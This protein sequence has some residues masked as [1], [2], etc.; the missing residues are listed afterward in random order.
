MP[1]VT[2]LVT[3]RA[4]RAVPAHSDDQDVIILQLGGRKIWRVYGA[5]VE[6]P[7]THEQLR[8]ALVGADSVRELEL[9][10]R[11]VLS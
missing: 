8:M 9:I 11:A 3:P 6:P 1:M 5:A 4:S 2:Q 10:T 7:Y